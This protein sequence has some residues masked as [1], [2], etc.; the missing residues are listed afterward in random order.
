MR[1][2]GRYNGVSNREDEI[3]IFGGD[4]GRNIRRVENRKDS[5]LGTIKMKI[6]SFQD[7]NNPKV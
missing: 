2:G 6:S 1:Y 4:A 5:S 7:K 3:A